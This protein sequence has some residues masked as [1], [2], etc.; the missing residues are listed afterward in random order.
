MRGN[1]RETMAYATEMCELVNER[2]TFDVSLWQ[3]L[4]G[5]PIGTVSF[6]M[7]VESRAAFVAGQATLLGDDEYLDAIERGK[8]LI[9]QPGEDRLVSMLHHAGGELRRADVGACANITTALAEVDRIADT[10]TW[11]VGMADLAAA[12]SGY[13]VHLGTL[14]HGPF[15]ELQW[16]SHRSDRA[17]GRRP[18]PRRSARGSGTRRTAGRACD[19]ST[20]PG[21]TRPAPR[22]DPSRREPIRRR[23]PAPRLAAAAGRRAPGRRS[24]RRWCPRGRCRARGRRRAPPVP[25]RAR[26][27]EAPAAPPASRAAHRRG[28]RRSASPLGAGGRPVGCNRARP[29]RRSHRRPARQRTTP[30]SGT[31]RGTARTARRP[32]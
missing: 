15:G 12:I 20:R 29:T 32:G 25:C 24:T 17:P 9:A 16:T 30:P 19:R 22:S 31:A 3:V 4:F 1:P 27:P 21:R 10:L 23:V 26:R 6:S 5:A 11:S 8:D 28:T 18:A 7:L 2:S 13:P 14:E